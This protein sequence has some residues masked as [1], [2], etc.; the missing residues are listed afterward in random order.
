MERPSV[1]IVL[2]NYHSEKNTLDCLHSLRLLN[3]SSVS[4]E[5]V[6]VQVDDD[7]P[8]ADT[9]F[10]HAY[11]TLHIVH[12]KNVGFSGGNN[13]G[14]RYALTHLKPAYVMLLNNDTTVDR[15][16]VANLVEVATKYPEKNAVFCPKI[17]FAPGSE[18]HTGEYA[19]VEQG[20]VLWYAGGIFDRKNVL[21]WHRGV[22]EVDHGQF[23][24]EETTAFGTGCCLFFPVNVWKT[25]GALDL[26]YFLYLEDLEWCLR[27]QKRKVPVVYAPSAHLWHKNAG[28][29]GGSGSDTQVYYQT[30]NRLYM[31]TKM[32][33][34]RTRIALVK[35]AVKTLKTGSPAMKEAVRDAFLFHLGKRKGTTR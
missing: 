17:Y 19:S 15:E 29:N 21:A 3:T 8:A 18:F 28:S 30:R 7:S 33:S 4:V 13:L 6:M 16:L 22:D 27:A 25:V 2:L 12:S 24:L 20:K 34:M 26:N 10:L 31:G 9:V 35:E 14:V 1:A 11:P 5:V 32:A 23:D